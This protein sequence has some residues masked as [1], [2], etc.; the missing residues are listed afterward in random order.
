[1]SSTNFSFNREVSTFM[2]V[3]IISSSGIVSKSDYLPATEK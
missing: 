2:L 1:L 3:A